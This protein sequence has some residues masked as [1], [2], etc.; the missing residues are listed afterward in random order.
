MSYD[1]EKQKHLNKMHVLHPMPG[2]YWHDMYSPVARVLD[3]TDDWIIVQKVSGMGGKEISD[4]DPKP[5]AMKKSA[6]RRWISYK[7]IA[8]ETWASVIPER[9]PPESSGDRK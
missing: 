8:G 5:C 4:T 9:Y 7:S 3:A 6:F 1:H 2:D